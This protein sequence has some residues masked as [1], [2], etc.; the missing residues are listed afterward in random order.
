M[1]DLGPVMH[2]LTI[3]SDN[4][5]MRMVY[6]LTMAL[7]FSPYHTLSLLRCLHG[8]S[9]SYSLRFS[10]WLLCVPAAIPN[11]DFALVSVVR[12]QLSG[13][14]SLYLIF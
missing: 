10:T 5:P 8:A 13:L 14:V 3:N 12:C 1:S 7:R 9:L 11:K 2:M 6:V 4:G